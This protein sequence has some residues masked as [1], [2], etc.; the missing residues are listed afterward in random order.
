M[1]S[2]SQKSVEEKFKRATNVLWKI[3]W[4]AIF[5]LIIPALITLVS[6]AIISFIA[7][8]IE[9]DGRPDPYVTI[10]LA[11]IVFIFAVL[12][13]Y[14]FFDRY[15]DTPMFFN[16][17]NNLTSRIHIFY[18]I[19]M[20]SFIVT[21]IFIF[22]TP[23]EYQF[24]LLPLVSFCVLYNIVYFYFSLKPIDFFDSSERAFKR[25]MNASLS[26]KQPY[27]FIIFI[28]YIIQII[29]LALIFETGW[30]WVFGLIFNLLFYFVTS[31]S[32]NKLRKSISSAIKEDRNFMM[33]LFMF[34][35]KF[36]ITI[37][38]L[39]FILLLQI[40]FV[41]MLFN[42]HNISY[43]LIDYINAGMYAVLIILIYL[44][45]RVYFLINYQKFLM[46]VA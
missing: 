32:T 8:L 39:D 46:R 26:I 43:T 15:R 1:E 17:E 19:S 3:W 33:D 36:S 27:N 20:I 21:P 23:P 41:I 2:K 42:V 11:V 38:S 18:L 10:G 9:L 28:N 5:I 24:E 40:P 6:F 12:F 16:Q 14:R 13:F 25:A 30:S 31:I 29:Y 22:I 37:L 35:R 44:K 4:F 7:G 45:V 34:R